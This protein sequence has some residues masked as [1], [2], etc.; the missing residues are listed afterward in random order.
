MLA[1]PVIKR[2]A[3]GATTHATAAVAF[4]GAL[5]GALVCAGPAAAQA[6]GPG[7]RAGEDSAWS[8]GLGVMSAQK[9][10]AGIERKN[11]LVPMIQ[12]ENKYVRVRGLGV[13]LKLPGLVM[14]DKQ[15]VDF[16]LVA[17][18]GAG[19]GYEASDAP[20][21]AGMSER[22]SGF[23]IGA[24]AEWKG[25]LA[26]LSTEW[27]SD[28][29]GNS[30]GQK[31]SLGVAKTWR[32][33]PQLLLTPRLGLNWQDAKFNDYYYGVR[34]SEARVGRSAYKADAG[35]NTEVGVSAV[36]LIDRHHSMMFNASVSS[37]SKEIKKSPLVDRS[38][39]NRVM[40][41]YVYRF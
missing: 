25:G 23:W 5:V 30:K 38:T 15:R 13:E 10:Y 16:S 27:V 7:L 34:A 14:S 40:A 22:K 8:L 2:H 19:S 4:A 29:S 39:E 24:K 17:K 26:D 32:V 1:T 31:L 41:A 35:A 9:A 3:R 6:Q 37:L 12:Y 20:I 33:S 11:S 21:L 36:Y 18:G 28:A